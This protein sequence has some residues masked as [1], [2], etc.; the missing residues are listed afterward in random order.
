MF[1][2]KKRNSNNYT[3]LSLLNFSN[4][5]G[6]VKKWF[7]AGAVG[8][9]LYSVFFII[10]TIYLAKFGAIH[11][12]ISLLPE[13]ELKGVNVLVFGTDDNREVKR[14][15]SIVVFHLDASRSRVGEIGRAHV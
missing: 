10:L 5:K 13:T 7:I 6:S 3:Q 9:F 11:Y 14:A 4:K 15:D 1:E 8:F 2:E 12:L